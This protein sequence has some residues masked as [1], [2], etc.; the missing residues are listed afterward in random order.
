MSLRTITGEVQSLNKTLLL[1]YTFLVCS[2]PL[3]IQEKFEI[4]IQGTSNLNK[5]CRIWSNILDR[6]DGSLIVRY[7][8]YE[9]CTSITIDVK[10]DNHHV[11]ESPY[12]ISNFIQ[13][14]TCYCPKES[15]TELL[16]NWH[17]DAIP[18]QIPKS[19]QTF[20][21]INWDVLRSKV[22][23]CVNFFSIF[24]LLFDMLYS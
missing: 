22:S 11:A 21:N 14:E 5:P 10:Y 24:L 1:C 17:C 12:K 4:V 16:H 8:V 2:I 18:P 9:T 15:V 7:K 20:K 23:F 3:N 19:F 13:P 6:K